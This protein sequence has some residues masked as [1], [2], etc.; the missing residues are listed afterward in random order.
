MDTFRVVFAALVVALAVSPR[1][2]LRWAMQ[3]SEVDDG[4]AEYCYAPDGNQTEYKQCAAVGAAAG[5]EFAGMDDFPAG[6]SQVLADG[7]RA[8]PERINNNTF[9]LEV[10]NNA[11]ECCGSKVL[12]H[13]EHAFAPQGVTALGLLST[14]HYAI[15][16][17]PE[18]SAFTL[19]VYFC[20]P[21]ARAQVLRFSKIVCEALQAEQCC[22]RVVRRPLNH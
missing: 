4:L 15:H 19:D 22:V 21:E 18:R 10:L 6:G 9:L 2:A 11:S 7:Y 14:S 8:C 3:V 13:T 17:W 20:T 5:E 12:S 16:T 1:E